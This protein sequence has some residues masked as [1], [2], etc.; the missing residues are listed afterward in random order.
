MF[1]NLLSG[2]LLAFAVGAIFVAATPLALA[3]TTYIAGFSIISWGLD[4]RH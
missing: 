4:R 3:T 1:A 2:T